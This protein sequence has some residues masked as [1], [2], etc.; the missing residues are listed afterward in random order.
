VKKTPDRKVGVL[1]IVYSPKSDEGG[2]KGEP[3]G[4]SR[5]KEKICLSY[6]KVTFPRPVREKIEN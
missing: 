1:S 6:Q 3:F 2:V 4:E 5:K